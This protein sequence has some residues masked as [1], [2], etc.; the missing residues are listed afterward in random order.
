MND[1]GFT[2]TDFLS[3]GCFRDW[4]LSPNEENS[5][6][7]E[8][9]IKRHPHQQGEMEWA[10]RIL[11]GM[12]QS[13]QVLPLSKAACLWAAIEA[14]IETAEDQPPAPASFLE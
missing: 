1:K 12:H 7:W 6:S 5:V 2:V 11:T 4:V 10:R 8:N 13:L 3:D 14:G 9:W